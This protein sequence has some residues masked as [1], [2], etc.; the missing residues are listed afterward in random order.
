MLVSLQVLYNFFVILSPEVLEQTLINLT[1]IEVAPSPPPTLTHPPPIY[2]RSKAWSGLITKQVINA[3][4]ALAMKCVV[5]GSIDY[6]QRMIMY[7]L[8]PSLT[9]TLGDPRGFARSHCLGGGGGVW[10][11]NW[12]NFLQFSKTRAGTSRFVS[13]K[14]GAAEKAG[15][16]VLF[17]VNFCKNSNVYCI[18]DNIDDHF[19]HLGHFD[20]I[21]RSSKS[22]FCE[23]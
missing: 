2:L 13:K 20:K 9:I 17:Y 7:P 16:P 10:I 14:L 18:S 22:H 15:V 8:I 1:A 12:R 5:N 4:S 19:G 21:F 23:C 11:L 6:F 3:I